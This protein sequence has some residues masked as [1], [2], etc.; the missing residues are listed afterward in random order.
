MCNSRL[1]QFAAQDGKLDFQEFAAFVK[2]EGSVQG[3]LR[4]LP[5][6]IDF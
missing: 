5:E 6:A 3:L 4:L 2:V 1:Q